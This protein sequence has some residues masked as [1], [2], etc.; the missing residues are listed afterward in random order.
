M[1]MIICQEVIEV[2]IDERVEALKTLK[3]PESSIPACPAI[4]VTMDM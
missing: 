2:D 4:S 3:N 1:L